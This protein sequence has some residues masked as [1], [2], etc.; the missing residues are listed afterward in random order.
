MDDRFEVVSRQRISMPENMLLDGEY[1]TAIGDGI[2]LRDTQTG[3]LYLW[4]KGGNCGGLTVMVDKDGKPLTSFR[5][6]I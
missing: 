6:T 2:V 5:V 1:W 3:V 4:T